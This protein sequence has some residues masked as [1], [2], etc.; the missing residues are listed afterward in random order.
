[1]LHLLITFL[2][3]FSSLVTW[4][5]FLPF[6][7]LPFLFI[8]LLLCVYFLYSTVFLFPY[9]SHLFLYDIFIL[10]IFQFFAVLVFIVKVVFSLFLFYN[11]LFFILLLL[12]HVN[13][14]TLKGAKFAPRRYLPSLHRRR[15]SPTLLPRLPPSVVSFL[16]PW[17]CNCLSSSR[18]FI[19]FLILLVNPFLPCHLHL[20]RLSPAQASSLH[21]SFP[22]SLPRS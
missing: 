18:V 21:P 8:F 13:V 15:R 9:C 4:L 10:L 22:P 3:F 16:S 7:L 17:F 6:V 19:F 2:V 5:L 20:L 1:M 14:I 12:R 11:L